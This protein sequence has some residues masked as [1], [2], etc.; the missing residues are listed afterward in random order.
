MGV[1]Y[2]LSAATDAVVISPMRS[3]KMRTLL[4]NIFFIIV[5]LLLIQCEFI[6]DP[7]SEKNDFSYQDSTTK[8]IKNG[9]FLNLEGI[10]DTYSLQDTISGEMILYNENN[11][12]GLDI[13]VGNHPPISG[14]LVF[15]QYEQLYYYYPSATGC[16]VF[17]MTLLPGDTLIEEIRWTQKINSTQIFPYG[18]DVFSGHYK[19]VGGF[20]GNSLFY[21][22]KLIK[23]IEITEEGDPISSVALRH[24]EVEDSIKIS[25]II[26]NRISSEQTFHLT[27]DNPFSYFFV[28]TKSATDTVLYKK[29]EQIPNFEKKLILDSKSDTRIYCFRISKIDPE[30]SGLSGAYYATFL[31]NCEERDIKASVITF[32]L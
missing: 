26:R 24:Y 13:Y 6:R 11:T 20:W 3:N 14:F 1:A 32:I 16:A 10:Q 31:L 30:L 21:T 22:N 2:P 18:L 4:L 19:I 9:I 27:N 5:I 23:W 28:S 12:E 15:D 29:F 8:I 17:D 7:I 25:F